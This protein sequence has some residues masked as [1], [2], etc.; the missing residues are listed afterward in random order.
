MFC[1]KA[2]AN[3]RIVNL[4]EVFGLGNVMMTPERLQNLTKNDL[5]IDYSNVD[6]LGGEFINYSKKFLT[7]ALYGERD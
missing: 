1:P 2:H 3:E 7:Q 6:R 4:Q 5:E